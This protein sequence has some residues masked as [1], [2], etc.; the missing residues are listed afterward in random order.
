MVMAADAVVMQ[1]ELVAYDAK[2]NETANVTLRAP[3]EI[4]E[5]VWSILL[6]RHETESGVHEEGRLG[7]VFKTKPHTT[8]MA[9]WGAP[10]PLVANRAFKVKV[11][12]TC[13]A[14]CRLTG[15]VVEIHDEAG[16]RVGEGALGKAPWPD[17]G[18]LYWTEVALTAPAAEEV[19]SWTVRFGAA[20]LALPHD[21]ASTT[22]AFRTAKPPENTVTIKLVAQATGVP[23]EGVEVRVGVY[24]ASTD[25]RGL[26]T[27]AV[28]KDTYHITVRKDGYRAEPM[29]VEVTRDVTVQ[30]EAVAVPTGAEMEE[31]AMRF[32]DHSWG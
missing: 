16:T 20:G 5:H 28:P 11:G 23:V 2:T 6:P 29:T 12:V 32:Q 19:P 25:E 7:M 14:M 26:A 1:S 30:V 27:V 15:H 21:A 18:A 13:S 31:R 9:V 10:A 22:V 4:G 3:V 24:E 8:S 17:T